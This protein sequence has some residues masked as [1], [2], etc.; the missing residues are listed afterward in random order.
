MIITLTKVIKV[1]R[2][3]THSMEYLLELSFH[4]CSIRN[5][6]NLLRKTEITH[7]AWEIKII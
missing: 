5:E 1:T 4:R 6:I 2:M 3:I 7:M